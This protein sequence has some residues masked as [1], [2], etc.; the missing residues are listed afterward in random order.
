MNVFSTFFVNLDKCSSKEKANLD[1]KTCW[2]KA[3][4]PSSWNFRLKSKRSEKIVNG[5]YS[6]ITERRFECGANW[7]GFL[8]C[9]MELINWLPE[10]T[11]YLV[12]KIIGIVENKR[13]NLDSSFG[14]TAESHPNEKNHSLKVYNDTY[15]TFYMHN[16]LSI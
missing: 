14:L 12:F 5:E 11:K 8:I 9:W 4:C 16:M 15:G 13:F 7:W 2:P 6:F 3:Q 1:W 10:I